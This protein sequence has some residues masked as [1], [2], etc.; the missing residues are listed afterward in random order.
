MDAMIACGQ[1]YAQ[2]Y[3]AKKDTPMV[4]HHATPQT[5][6]QMVHKIL[7]AH[8]IL[9]E[10][11]ANMLTLKLDGTGQGSAESGVLWHCHMEPMLNALTQFSP[12][13]QFTDVTHLIHFI[14]YIIGY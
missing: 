3:F 7:A 12:R 11:N 8:G 2:L 1:N 4:L 10:T 13:F 9:I 14:Q 6:V 5:I